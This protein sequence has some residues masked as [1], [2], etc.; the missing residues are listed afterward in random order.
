MKSGAKAGSLWRT[1]ETQP[2]LE[3]SPAAGLPAVLVAGRPRVVVRETVC[4]SILN[5]SSISD[6]SLNCYTG[7]M[8]GCVYCYARFMQRFHPHAEPWGA[9]VDVKVNAVETLRRQLRRAR[10][11]DVF[12]SSACDGWQPIEASRRLT[13]GCCELLLEGG[14][15]VNVLTKSELV[16]RDFDL[17]AGRN[18]RIGVTLTTLDDRLSRLWEPGAS[19]VAARCRVVAEARRAGLRT[20]IMFAPLLPFLSDTTDSLEAMFERAADLA[21]DDLWVDAL[22]PRP[23]VWSS[24][25]DLL[26]REF[27]ELHEPYRRIL[28]NEGARAVYLAEVRNR[29]AAAAARFKLQDRLTGC[30]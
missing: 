9:F 6:Y 7:C 27:P 23:K 28:F 5:Q 3:S 13:R 17:F 21:V 2:L 30:F 22:N 11:G 29:V 10:P 26:R 8:N 15:S 14:F 24:V 4:R 20:G 12:M 16:M 1:T 25:S 18:G 19:S